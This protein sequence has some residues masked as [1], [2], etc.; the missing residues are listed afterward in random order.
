MGG[1]KP[2]VEAAKQPPSGGCVLKP[3]LAQSEIVCGW[4][5][6]SGGC[7]LKQAGSARAGGDF[8]QLPS[9]GCVL[10]LE[11]KNMFIVSVVSYWHEQKNLPKRYS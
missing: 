3:L 10:K 9:G 11:A 2:P 7:V 4:Q 6:P 1:K 8:G 5:P